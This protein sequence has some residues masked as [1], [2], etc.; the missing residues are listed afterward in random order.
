MK[1]RWFFLFFLVSGFCSLVYQVVW[2]R[3]AMAR[4]G[5][6]APMVSLVVSVFMAGLA[7]GSWGAGRLSRRLTTTAAAMRLYAA[8]EAAIALSALAVPFGFELGRRA[9]AALGGEA[10]W[11]SLSHYAG[12][13]ACVALVLLPFSTCMG[14]VVPLAMRAIAIGLPAESTR[15]FS[16]LYLANVI[17]A[18]M[19]T[20]AS[21]FVLIELL[22]FRHTLL[23]MAMLNLALAALAVTVSAPHVA[24][25]GT[26]EG[27][28]PTG[29]ASSASSAEPL[30]AVLF[31]TGLASM[32][33][34][35][36][37]IRMFTPYLGSVVYAFALVLALYLVATF[38]GS[39]VYR[40]VAVR[41]EL[42][43]AAGPSLLAASAILGLLPLVAGDPRAELGRGI[44]WWG[45]ARVAL[46]I[47]PFCGV[48]GF[49][50]PLSVDRWSAGD[51][52]RAGRAYAVN[53]LGCILG[54]LAAGF[55]LLPLVGERGALLGLALPLMALALRVTPP[56]PA[57]L[58]HAAAV[59]G[60]ALLIGLP[61][62]AYETIHADREVQRD[63][64]ATVAAV[65]KGDRRRLLVNGV[66]MTGLT[67]TTKMM[68]H[69]PLAFLDSPPRHVLVICFGMGT[70]FRSALSWSTR[71]TS[72]ELVPSVPRLFHYFHAD[73]DEV[74]RRPA[75]V[76]VID[77]GRRFLERSRDTDDLV[78]VDPPPPPEAAGSSLLYSREFNELIRSRLRPGG[79]LQQWLPGG[80]PSTVVSAT[81]A[82]TEVFPH[83]RVFSPMTGAGLHYLA[84]DS[85]LPSRTPGELAARL[86][87]AARADLL[88]WE[89]RGG[90]TESAFAAVVGGEIA[91]ERL[92]AIAPNTPALTDDRPVNEYYFLRRWRTPTERR[93]HPWLR[94]A[95]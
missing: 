60:S 68:A 31:S 88:E 40:R 72:V 94:A 71:V 58:R 53:V 30:L 36:V 75:G 79:L 90:T 89:T 74:M 76:V 93:G 59:F 57:R 67:P 51:A 37:W 15:S 95:S 61:T 7:L 44:W 85:P 33:M 62:R 91:L 24:R 35:I 86:P 25:A 27:G 87:P 43:A 4:F 66:G 2:M 50:T 12:A 21:A 83:V 81:R 13:G 14:A 32:G 73:A 84:G 82:L 49:L 22:G 26:L 23:A 69:L 52:S 29:L 48:V 78:L 9:L 6:T 16:Y 8:A 19:G 3:L 80:D 28:T 39:A 11:G 63:Y 70:S 18:A 17:G 64:T 5:V 65:G 77:D 34:E 56:G 55:A 1:R 20:L 45:G 38:V 47:A 92:Y 54:P 41:P 42:W 10:A 46:G